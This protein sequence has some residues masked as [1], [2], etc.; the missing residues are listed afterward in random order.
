MD[1]TGHVVHANLAGHAMLAKSDVL[2]AAGRRLVVNDPQQAD[3]ALADIFA[4][5][6][7]GD[8]AVGIK[9]CSGASRG[10]RWATPRRACAAAHIGRKTTCRCRLRRGSGTVRTQSNPRY[11]VAAGGYCRGLQTHANR[12]A[13]IARR[14]R[15]WR[16]ARGCGSSWHRRDDGQNSSRKR[17]PKDWPLSSSYSV[18]LVAEFSSNPLVRRPLVSQIGAHFLRLSFKRTM[19]ELAALGNRNQSSNLHPASK[20]WV[21]NAKA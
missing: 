9:G 16:R 19:D 1:A 8:A 21:R 3:Q 17:L 10:P 7:N 11:A 20:N 5:A 4:T 15:G 6:G 13:G 14:R 12:T 2:H 18:K